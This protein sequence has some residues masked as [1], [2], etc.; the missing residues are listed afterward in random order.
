VTKYNNPDMLKNILIVGLGGFL[1]TVLRFLAYHFTKN[2]PSHWI[3]LSVN[4]L[5]CLLIGVFLG[6]LKNEGLINNEKLFLATGFCGGF[7][8]FSA[9]SMENVNLFQE[10]KFGLAALYI[11]ISVL[12][13][14]SLSFIGY[15]L[16]NA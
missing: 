12:G 15:K 5:G 1:G 4:L 6:L 3:T 2:I 10:G 13:G 9:F 7:T 14:L 11:M 8:T 16:T